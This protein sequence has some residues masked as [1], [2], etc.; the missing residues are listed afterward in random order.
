MLNLINIKIGL[1][2]VFLLTFISFII[3]YNYKNKFNEF[4]SNYSNANIL[5]LIFS[6]NKYKNRVNKLRQ[7]GY[8]DS[9]KKY[10]IDYLIVTG[11]PKLIPLLRS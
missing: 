1:L 8:L 5:V 6:C 4:F 3:K 7:I 10:N 11:D 9:F 2:L